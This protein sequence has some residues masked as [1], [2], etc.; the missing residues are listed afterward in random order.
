MR[1][2][3]TGPS[4]NPAIAQS[5]AASPT[6]AEA[7]V[8]GRAGVLELGPPESATSIEGMAP[9]SRGLE[10]I[11]LGRL[12]IPQELAHLYAFLAS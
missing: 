1:Y 10:R 12:G 6:K 3:R 4:T 5:P 11:P 8:L 9:E 7:K 2:P